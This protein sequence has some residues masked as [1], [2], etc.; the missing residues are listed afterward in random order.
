MP[1]AR[2][3]PR[4]GLHNS[5]VVLI[6]KALAKRQA[7]ER[8]SPVLSGPVCLLVKTTGLRFDSRS[9]VREGSQFLPVWSFIARHNQSIE[10]ITVQL[11]PRVSCAADAQALAPF[12]HFLSLFPT[13]HLDVVLSP[14]QRC[15]VSCHLE[16]GMNSD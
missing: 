14:P 9:C 15:N 3:G 5:E 10:R 7:K 4:K 8:E 11:A 1:T 12:G 2:K 16:G 6:T 13:P